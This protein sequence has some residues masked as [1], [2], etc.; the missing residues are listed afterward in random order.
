MSTFKAGE[1]DLLILPEKNAK[2]TIVLE[3]IAKI[4]DISIDEVR[5]RLW[6]AI[7]PNVQSGEFP[8]TSN[9]SQGSQKLSHAF[10]MSFSGEVV[11][12][13]IQTELGVVILHDVTDG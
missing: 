12:A 3:K 6:R 10:T 11:A 7:M 2:F 9:I 5:K 4:E 1:Y 8:P 13:S